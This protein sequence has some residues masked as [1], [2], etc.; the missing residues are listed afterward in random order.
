[1]RYLPLVDSRAHRALFGEEWTLI[2]Q[3]NGCVPSSYRNESIKHI[4]EKLTILQPLI[5]E[6]FLISIIDHLLNG[7]ANNLFDNNAK[8]YIQQAIK[9]LTSTDMDEY[10]KNQNPLSLKHLLL[11]FEK[12]YITSIKTRENGNPILFHSIY[13]RSK[14]FQ[15][16]SGDPF[17]AINLHIYTRFRLS[18]L[19]DTI[20]NPIFLKIA[21]PITPDANAYRII[22]ESLLI[23]EK[24][25]TIAD[26][27]IRFYCGDAKGAG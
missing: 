23:I 5:G 11:Q 24:G 12:M 25:E 10:L 1:M 2:W 14:V 4:T 21:R 17:Q 19:L 16:Y 15:M 9:L 3:A 26:L 20:S 18:C 27:W 22:S 8:Q 7:K 6:P 13:T